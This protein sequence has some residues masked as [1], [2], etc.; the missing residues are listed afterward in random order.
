MV[1]R[2]S[3][4]R[5]KAR[6][7]LCWWNCWLC[8]SLAR[9]SSLGSRGEGSSPCLLFVVC[10]CRF[11][12]LIIFCGSLIVLTTVA[13]SSSKYISLR[14]IH[15]N[16]QRSNSTQ[17]SIIAMSTTKA[18]FVSIFWKIIGV[19]LWQSRKVCCWWTVNCCLC[20]SLNFCFVFICSSSLDLFP[21]EWS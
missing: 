20:S 15:S 6:V 12:D 5:K 8:L 2:W 1:G 7:S 14:I 9:C 18:E 11:L 19:R 13:C 3:F 17:K 21:V 10:S 4:H 16:H